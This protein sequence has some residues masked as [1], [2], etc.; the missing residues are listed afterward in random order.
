[1][2]GGTPA[3][4]TPDR[5][6]EATNPDRSGRCSCTPPPAARRV[7]FHEGADRGRGGPNN[8]PTRQTSPTADPRSQPKRPRTAQTHS[9]TIPTPAERARQAALHTCPHQATDGGSSSCAAP[10]PA[11]TA[12]L[13][14]GRQNTADTRPGGPAV[15]QQPDRGCGDDPLKAP[16]RTPGVTAPAPDTG[17]DRPA[18][19]ANA[20]RGSPP[21]LRRSQ[22]TGTR[23][24][25]H[26]SVVT[27]QATREQTKKLQRPP[28]LRSPGAPRTPPRPV[29]CPCSKSAKQGAYL[30]DTLTPSQGTPPQQAIQRTRTGRPCPPHPPDHHNGGTRTSLTGR[31]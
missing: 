4:P 11:S 23:R 12:G 14:P 22:A 31:N 27:T 25:H 7:V 13:L 26:N 28:A 30:R 6:Q 10:L 20:P 19:Q 16:S 5:H 29:A 21:W 3:S 2:K 8:P 9:P 17:T 18:N 15:D 24:T 1:M